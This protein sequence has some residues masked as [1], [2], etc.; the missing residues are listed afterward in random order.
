MELVQGYQSTVEV[1]NN[2][3]TK[4][5]NEYDTWDDLVKP[6][7]EFKVLEYISKLSIFFPQNVIEKGPYV[8]EY[9]YVEG[10]I[11]KKL[12]EN[13]FN[14]ICNLYYILNKNGFNHGDCNIKNFIIDSNDKVHI[15]DFGQAYS[16]ERKL[17]SGEIK[18]GEEWEYIPPKL[19][20][21][22]KEYLINEQFLNE[23]EE[24]IDSAD[25]TQAWVQNYLSLTDE[26][27]MEL[28]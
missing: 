19:S 2:R 23:I 24:L 5:I 22:T 1:K 11:M 20:Y 25:H 12:T 21:E 6:W 14:Q 8:I 27:K 3:I 4:Y 26:E 7:K 10:T 18:D 17:I 15:I 16:K 28:Y 13:Y 9:D